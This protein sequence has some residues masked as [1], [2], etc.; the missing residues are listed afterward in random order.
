MFVGG[1]FVTLDFE[2]EEDEEDGEEDEEFHVE[3]EEP[4]RGLRDD[5]S[6]LF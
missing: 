5:P 1:A 6:A 2:D 4:V 3:E